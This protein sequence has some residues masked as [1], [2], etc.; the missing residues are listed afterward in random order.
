MDFSRREESVCP[1]TRKTGSNRS[2]KSRNPGRGMSVKGKFLCAFAGDRKQVTGAGWCEG[3]NC[4]IFFSLFVPAIFFLFALAIQLSRAIVILLVSSG[5]K[6]GF[7]I[8]KKYGKNYLLQRK[9]N[10]LC[11]K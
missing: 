10:P 5:R 3:L 2:R 6:S 8:T 7:H 9:W 1:A 4:Q 11:F